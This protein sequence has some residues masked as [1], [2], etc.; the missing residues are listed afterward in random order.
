MH[1]RTRMCVRGVCEMGGGFV[2]N[3]ARRLEFSAVLVE[4]SKRRVNFCAMKG[5]FSSK[6]SG[7]TCGAQMVG[8]IW[9]FARID[10]SLQRRQRCCMS[11]VAA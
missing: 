1:G 8:Q 5:H 11:A 6:V 10:V 4:N 2:G 7:K 9:C 3:S